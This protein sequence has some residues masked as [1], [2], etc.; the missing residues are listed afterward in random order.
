MCT[1]RVLSCSV[2]RC[3]CVLLQVDVNVLPGD[4]AKGDA[5]VANRYGLLASKPSP[6]VTKIHH[7][8]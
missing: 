6:T 8:E 2:L 1:E 7:C 5:P 3:V 4:V